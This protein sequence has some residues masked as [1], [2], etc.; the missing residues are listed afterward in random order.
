MSSRLP[1][2]LLLHNQLKAGA[3]HYLGSKQLTAVKPWVRLFLAAC[4]S[5]PEKVAARSAGQA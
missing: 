5:L 3:L 1:W 4:H 2:Q